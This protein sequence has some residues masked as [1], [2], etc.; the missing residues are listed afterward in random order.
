[1]NLF[2]ISLIIIAFI[3]FQ[4]KIN[5]GLI[6]RT[7]APLNNKRNSSYASGDSQ[8][9]RNMNIAMGWGKIAP[10]RGLPGENPTTLPLRTSS[11]C[12]FDV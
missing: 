8:P 3:V 6:I 1:M 10:L 12:T 4:V 9:S 7:N 2:R 5:R 11:V